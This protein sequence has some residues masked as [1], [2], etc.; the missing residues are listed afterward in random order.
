MDNWFFLFYLLFPYAFWF[1][2][3][4]FWFSHSFYKKARGTTHDLR[5]VEMIWEHSKGFER[6]RQDVKGYA[7][8]WKDSR[9][10]ERICKD[11]KGFER[12]REDLSGLKGDEWIQFFSTWFKG[13]H[14]WPKHRRGRWTEKPL[15]R[16]KRTQRRKSNPFKSFQILSNPSKAFRIL[17]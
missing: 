4:F 7:M 5:V 11:L 13:G 9:G 6:I 16:G 15:E 8:F 10:F 3:G 1:C 17:S 12:I 2:I 14:R